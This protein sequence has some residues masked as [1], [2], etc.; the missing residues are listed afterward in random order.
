M[1]NGNA[2]TYEIPVSA[3]RRALNR[4]MCAALIVAAVGLVAVSAALH[5]HG[6][7]GASLGSLVTALGTLIVGVN[8]V[9][10]E[11]PVTGVTAPTAKQNSTHQQMSAVITGDGAATTFTITHNWGLTAAQNTN[12]FPQVEY[13]QLL[14]AGYTAAPLIT[15]KN[16]NTVVFSCTAFTGAGLRVRLIRPWSPTL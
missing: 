10:Y 2:V 8:T 15:S 4:L 14:A 12:G 11:Y 13:E 9:T 3:R 6:Q 5:A 7:G 16:P 1:K